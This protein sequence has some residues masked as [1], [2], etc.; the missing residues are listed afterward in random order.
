MR[1]LQRSDQL[2]IRD[3]DHHA[4]SEWLPTILSEG[5][6]GHQRYRLISAFDRKP[7]RRTRA[8]AAA[9]PTLQIDEAGRVDATRVIAQATVAVGVVWIVVPSRTLR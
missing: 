5:H 8:I 3:R 1:S 4:C 7:G 2:T 9:T 6:A